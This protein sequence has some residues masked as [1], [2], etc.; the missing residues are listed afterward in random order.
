MLVQATAALKNRGGGGGGGD[1]GGGGVDVKRIGKPAPASEESGEV[2]RSVPEYDMVGTSSCTDCAAGK[3]HTKF[4]H[5]PGR[6]P[7]ACVVQ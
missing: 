4:I 3:C 2:Q 6:L 1:G 5:L 7:C